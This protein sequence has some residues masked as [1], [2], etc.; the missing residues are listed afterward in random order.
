MKV[1]IMELK[2][3]I[4][5]TLT[6]IIEAITESQ[7]AIKGTGAVIN[8]HQ[9]GKT[10]KSYTG[11]N[12]QIFEIEFD[13]G[14]TISDSSGSKAGIGIFMAG[15]GVGTKGELKESN[16]SQNRIKFQIPVAYPKGD[17]SR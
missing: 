2:D 15:L 6:E 7:A 4:K 10:E 13:V 16:I 17:E 5:G 3:F 1:E 14:V 11:D 8:P 9:Y 12:I